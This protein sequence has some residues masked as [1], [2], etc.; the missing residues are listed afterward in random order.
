[1]LK[2]ARIL[3]AVAQNLHQLAEEFVKGQDLSRVEGKCADM[4][5]LFSQFLS[6]RGVASKI[7]DARDYKGPLA[8]VGKSNHVLASVNG[9]YVDFTAKQFSSSAAPIVIGSVRSLTRD[10]GVV[11]TYNNYQDFLNNFSKT[12]K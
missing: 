8:S 11:N 7:I 3:Q 10:W 1:M 9:S 4:A 5:K 12:Q 2:V 6:D